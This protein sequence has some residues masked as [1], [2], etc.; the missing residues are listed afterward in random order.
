MT[1]TV[2]SSSQTIRGGSVPLASTSTMRAIVFDRYGPPEVLRL[3]EIPKPAVGDDE[4]LVRVRAASLNPLDWHFMTGLPHV[5][6]VQFGL[7]RPKVTGIGADVAGVVEAVGREVTGFRPGDEVFGG[8]AGETPD[9]PMP[10]LGSCAEF[11]CASQNSIVPKPAGL[12]FEQAAAVPVAAQTALQGLRDQGRI[13]AGQH[14]LIN[15]A[16]GGVGTFAVQLAKWLDT[17]VTGVCSGRNVD[18]VRSL[19]ADHVID[20]TTDDFTAGDR[21]YDLMLDNIG[22]RSIRECRRVLRSEAT[23]VASYGQPEHRWLGPTAQLLQMFAM[24]PFVS[25]KMVTWV[26]E[27]AS[28]DLLLLSELLEAGTIA[29]V[30]DRSYPLAQTADAMRHLEAGH[31]RG[32]VIISV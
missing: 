23:Y 24:R 13:H 28:D 29:S 4:V 1:S 9:H 18:L 7:R 25:Q 2:R 31:A 26:T 19:G 20:Y 22:N 8:V 16:S 21:R 30:I 11:V 12:T 27:P 17:E 14:V 32:K 6:R 5:G 10:K 3:E 15:G